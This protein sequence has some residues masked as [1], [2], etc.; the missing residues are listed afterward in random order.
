MIKITIASTDVRNQS[1]IGKASNKPYDM[2]FQVVYVHTVDGQGNTNPFPEKVEL[3][4]DKDSSG[5]VISY[6]VGEFFMADSSI[7]VDRSGNLALR[8]RL[9]PARPAVKAAA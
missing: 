5:K 6:P 1:G 8:P 2:N 9:M 4:L 7:Y 3:V